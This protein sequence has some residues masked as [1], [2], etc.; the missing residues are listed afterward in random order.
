[1]RGN[2]KCFALHI[3]K[4][5]DIVEINDITKDITTEQSIDGQASEEQVAEK[6]VTTEQ[7]AKEQIAEKQTEEKNADTE[8]GSLGYGYG[9]QTAGAAPE[10]PAKKKKHMPKAL[11]AL[12]L[13]IL[14]GVIAAGTFIGVTLLYGHFF[15]KGMAKVIAQTETEQVESGKNDGA[16]IDRTP[17]MNEV[18]TKTTDVAKIVEEAMPSLVQITSTFSVSSVFGAYDQTDSGSG[19]VIRETDDEYFIVTN[20]HVIEGATAVEAGFLDEENIPV[21]IRGRDS[22]AD[23]AVLSVKKSDLSDATRNAVKVAK[24]GNSDN[25][26]PGQIA[27]VIGNAMGY[28]QSATVGYI[29]SKTRE[30]TVDQKTLNLIQTDAAINPG[31]SG[32]ALLNIDG[33]V[34]GISSSK[35]AS[36]SVQGICF[37]I[38]INSAVS[39][40]EDIMNKVELKEEDRGYLGVYMK[41]I[42]DEEANEYDMPRG[43]YVPKLDEGAAAEK[44][45]IQPRDI[46]TAIDGN[47]FE[48][49]TE[50]RDYITSKPAGT[51]ITVTV[52]RLVDGEYCEMSFDAVLG[53][54]PEYLQ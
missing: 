34:V 24:L 37:A 17:L 9:Y 51:T 16:L 45:G 38:P 32:G 35:F 18:D 28:G 46:I 49:S 39:S 41:D 12:L 20:A 8:T 27:I 25:I 21:E 2:A 53:Q 31:N 11:S 10:K 52:Q 36:S 23:L 48:D 54:N 29:S 44:A 14:F 50:M 15:P 33:E 40:L 6:Q 42:T 30:F 47:S 3:E 5:D 13:A 4:G 22:V 43:V 1:M 26:K 7:V 19:I